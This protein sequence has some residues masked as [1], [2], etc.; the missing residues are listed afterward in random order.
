MPR[1]Y[2]YIRYRTIVATGQSRREQPTTGRMS[3]CA[4]AALCASRPGVVHH[5]RSSTRSRVPALLDHDGAALSSALRTPKWGH[6]AAA[7]PA[8]V[9]RP[10]QH[11][12]E[13]VNQPSSPPSTP[14]PNGC[15]GGA[16]AILKERAGRLLDGPATFGRCAAGLQQQRRILS[17]HPRPGTSSLLRPSG[18]G[19]RPRRPATSTPPVRTL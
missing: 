1:W 8:D 11:T 10:I 9:R 19:L 12:A 7:P 5:G 14:L 16:S 6:A 4:L 13:V 2:L 15:P 18:R 3:P 17:R